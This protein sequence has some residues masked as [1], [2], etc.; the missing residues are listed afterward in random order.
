MLLAFV[1]ENSDSK[2]K[3]Y[4]DLSVAL[5]NASCY[6]KIKREVQ[7]ILSERG[8]DPKIEF[9]GSYLF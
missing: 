2:Y 7:S 9:K 3:D 5:I 8:W 1:D 4:L 6:P